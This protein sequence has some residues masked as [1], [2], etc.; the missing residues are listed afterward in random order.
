MVSAA[1]KQFDVVTISFGIRNVTDVTEALRE[2]YRVLRPGGRVLVLEFSLPDNRLI[3]GLYLFYLRYVLPRI[4]VLLR[5]DLSAFR[6]LN[7]TIETFPCGGAFCDMLRAAGFTAIA[8]HAMTFGAVTIY[9]GD[10]PAMAP[11]TGA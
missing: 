9:Q 4:A 2:M 7:E 11:E 6:Y 8:A 1:D 10:R 3:Q 5:G